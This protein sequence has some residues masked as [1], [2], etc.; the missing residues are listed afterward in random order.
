MIFLSFS[1]C[2]QLCET[3]SKLCQQRQVSAVGQG[4]CLSLCSLLESR[5]IISLKKAKEAR[6]TKV[7]TNLITVSLWPRVLGVAWNSYKCF[8]HKKIT[9]V[10]VSLEDL[11]LN[12]L[13]YIRRDV[14]CQ[15]EII[16]EQGSKWSD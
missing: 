2:L 8:M 5:G 12:T 11:H 16:H 1:F 15:G 14:I 7:N 3:Y 4:E 9:A 13:V 10:S 6:L